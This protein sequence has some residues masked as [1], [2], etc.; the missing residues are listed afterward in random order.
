MTNVTIDIGNT[1]ISF[2][3][4]KKN[5]LLKY[6]KI[7]KDK[8]DL[9]VL[10]RLRNKFFGEKKINLLISSVVPSSEKI[11]KSFLGDNLINFFSLKDL[12]KKINIEVN[13][14]KKKKSETTDLLI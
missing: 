14:K 8:L 11:I 5:R 7:P 12:L 13:I 3:M 4:F 10:N 1:I 2:C 6:T 9:K